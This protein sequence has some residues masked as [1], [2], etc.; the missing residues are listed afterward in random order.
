MKNTRSCTGKKRLSLLLLTACFFTLFAQ[1][2]SPTIAEPASGTAQW[3]FMKGVE[4]ILGL[5][6]NTYLAN[7]HF[8]RSA[9]MG[10]APAIKALADS[11]YSGDGIDEDKQKA[12]ELYKEAAD[13]GDGA[14]QF[15]LG[16]IYLRGY[17]G[18]KDPYLAFYYLCLTTIN[19][20]LDEM[21]QD[22]AIYRDEA[23]QLLDSAQ[24]QDIYRKIAKMPNPLKRAQNQGSG[25]KDQPPK[26][27]L[28]LSSENQGQR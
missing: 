20:D 16:I 19:E 11:Y 15:N 9:S 28:K 3:H 17:A 18:D 1:Q 4:E 13:K 14:A 26:T 7:E 23:G 5:N 27:P 22:A 24:L 2:S 12:L 8:R 10:Y 25:L 21:A 6:K